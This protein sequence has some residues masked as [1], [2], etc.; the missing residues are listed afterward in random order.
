MFATISRRITNSTGFLVCAGVLAYA[1]YLQFQEGLDPC[2]LCIFQRVA[3]IA[4]GLIFLIAAIHNAGRIG[5]RV[6]AVLL[7]LAGLAGAAVAG[8][9]IWLQSL[10]PEQVPECGPGLDYMLEVFPLTDALRMAF[11]GSGECAEVDWVFL[12]LSMPVWSLLCFIG[13]ITAGFVR[14][15]V[16]D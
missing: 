7:M 15:W 10:P 12:G 14:N 16:S 13:L 1:W 5:S 8:R 6:Y 9:H 11:T 3:F 4:M 2:P